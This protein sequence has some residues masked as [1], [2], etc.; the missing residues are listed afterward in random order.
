[1]GSSST[2]ALRPMV[3]CQLFP[4]TAEAYANFTS[5]REYLDS[6][7]QQF[8]IIAISEIWINALTKDRE[9]DF[10]M[11]GYE[12]SYINRHNKGG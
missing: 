10:D 4:S 12:L 6:F 1:M 5:I 7:S 9:L 8:N 3:N 2:G 11:D